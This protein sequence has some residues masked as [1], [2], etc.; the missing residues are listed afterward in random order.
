MKFRI[1]SLDSVLWGQWNKDVT[2]IKY[3]FAF[4]LF[5]SHDYVEYC[6]ESP[7]QATKKSEDRVEVLGGGKTEGRSGG[8]GRGISEAF[9]TFRHCFDEHP[10]PIPSHPDLHQLTSPS[11]VSEH[12]NLPFTPWTL[13][14]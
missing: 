8:V 13:S 7:S 1:E 14:R 2:Y 4:L 11:F 5:S 3:S 12:F 6:K 10:R 9:E